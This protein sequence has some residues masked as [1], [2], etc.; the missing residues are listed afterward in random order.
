[1]S[2][3]S[4]QGMLLAAVSL[5]SAALVTSHTHESRVI[6]KLR[7]RA[8]HE[9]PTHH[10]WSEIRE[11]GHMSHGR[12]AYLGLLWG[13]GKREKALTIHSNTGPKRIFHPLHATTTHVYISIYDLQRKMRGALAAPTRASMRIQGRGEARYQR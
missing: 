6:D 9:S 5:A 4:P 10:G 12:Q 13:N 8:T 3:L 7:V 2:N 11:E 1:M